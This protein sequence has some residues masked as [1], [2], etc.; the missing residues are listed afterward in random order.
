MRIRIAVALS[1]LVAA[2]AW[3]AVASTQEAPTSSGGSAPNSADLADLRQRV[4]EK[5]Q[6]QQR[7][8]LGHMER[9]EDRRA[10][11]EAKMAQLGNRA[12]VETIPPVAT[13]APMATVPPPPD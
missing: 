13:T 10:E 3:G 9:I 7:N 12:P 2:F 6:I 5:T 1:L 4:D 11:H 8:L